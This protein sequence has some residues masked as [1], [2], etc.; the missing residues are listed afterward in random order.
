[1]PVLH[2]G[3]E[4]ADRFLDRR[5]GV[6]AMHLVQV[7]MVQLQPLQAGLDTLDD[8]APRQ[9]ARIDAAGAGFAEDL[10]RHDHILARHLQVLQRL[11][12][13]DFRGA[14]GIDVRG[15]DEI[16]AGVERMADQ[17][18]GIV[19]SQ[20]TDLAPQLALATEGHGA[21]A[22]LGN[23]QAG[24]AEWVVAHGKLLGG[25]GK[26]AHGAWHDHGPPMHAL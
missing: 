19:L 22:Q 25:R 20:I 10:G 15:V 5:G 8:V 7:D 26:G 21:K 6:E 17:A 23:E 13:D 24:L 4:R 1:M 18:V 14:A 12:G 11:T 9:A 2:Q 16:D 3:V